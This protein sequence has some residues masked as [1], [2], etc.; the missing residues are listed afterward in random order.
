MWGEHTHLHLWN[1]EVHEVCEEALRYEA[2]ALTGRYPPSPT[3]P[4]REGGLGGPVSHQ[5]LVVC[6]LVARK[7]LHK[8]EVNDYIWYMYI[9]VIVCMHAGISAHV[10][11]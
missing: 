9:H 1:A 2:V 3:R 10:Q 6:L 8:A 7:L 4:L 11:I 5:A